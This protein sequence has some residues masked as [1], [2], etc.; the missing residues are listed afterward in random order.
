MSSLSFAS[1]IILFHL[2]VTFSNDTNP[3]EGLY[4]KKTTDLE[5]T[6]PDG[7]NFLPFTDSFGNDIEQMVGGTVSDFAEKCYANPQCIGFNTNGYLKNDVLPLSEFDKW[8]YTDAS[9]GLYLRKEV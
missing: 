3:L 4:V 2:R 9:E 7:F 5:T 6:A 8:N 1:F